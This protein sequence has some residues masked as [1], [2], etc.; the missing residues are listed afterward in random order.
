MYAI[1]LVGPIDEK[2]GVGVL[3]RPTPQ[4]D[5]FIANDLNI[6]RCRLRLEERFEVARGLYHHQ[7]GKRKPLVNK[8]VE[9]IR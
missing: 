4:L 3:L 9:A 7:L 1:A 6:V 2:R 8:R 5:R